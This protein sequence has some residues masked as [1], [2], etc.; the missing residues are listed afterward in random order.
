MTEEEAVRLEEAVTLECVICRNKINPTDEFVKVGSK[1]IRSLAHACEV[2]SY[3]RLTVFFNSYRDTSSKIPLHVSCRKRII[4][5]RNVNS[6]N[7][8]EKESSPPLKKT[9]SS[10]DMFDWKAHCFVCG[11]ICD[12]KHSSRNP[13]RKVESCS[14]RDRILEVSNT[15][16]HSY[17]R[18]RLINCFDLVAVKAIYHAR[19]LS[20]LCLTTNEI[21]KNETCDERPMQQEIKDE[22]SEKT[23]KG[24]GRPENS[25]AAYAFSQTCEWFES[26]CEPISLQEFEEK[27]SSLLGQENMCT[28]KW[29]KVKLNQK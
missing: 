13:I 10:T 24:P 16:D 25:E 14:L 23:K 3:E 26:S 11:L 21:F 7:G 6:T 2:K 18:H 27:M 8:D 19:C 28:R 17:L 22:K 15:E 12:F 1:G 4:D 5:L 9:R 29:L 20:M